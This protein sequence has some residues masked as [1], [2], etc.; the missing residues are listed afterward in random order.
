M[1]LVPPTVR[2]LLKL[3]PLR[4]SAITEGEDPKSCPP[5]CFMI[6]NTL[7]MSY[8]DGMAPA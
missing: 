4:G 6:M 3:P 2:L 5:R 8:P 1:T 7:G